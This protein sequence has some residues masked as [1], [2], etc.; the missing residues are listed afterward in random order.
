MKE[1]KAEV[2]FVPGDKAWIIYERKVFEGEI[3]N[4]IVRFYN[5]G[6]DILSS[7]HEFIVVAKTE[8]TKYFPMRF[9]V[10]EKRVFLT[11]EEAQEL[12]DDYLNACD[13]V[14][15][16]EEHMEPDLE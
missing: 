9:S 4:V 2:P 8:N 10:D 15:E 12:L 1:L 6:D 13:E 5:M 11:E 3:Q 7:S 16:F 14:K